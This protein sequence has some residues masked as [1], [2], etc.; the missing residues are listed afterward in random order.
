MT[1][2]MRLATFFSKVLK[3]ATLIDSCQGQRGERDAEAQ[4]APAAGLALVLLTLLGFAAT[5][6]FES[7][8]AGRREDLQTL[9]PRRIASKLA[10]GFSRLAAL[11]CGGLIA[12]EAVAR[13]LRNFRTCSNPASLPPGRAPHR[14]GLAARELREVRGGPLGIADRRGL[15]G[16]GTVSCAEHAAPEGD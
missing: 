1:S 6:A 5:Y 14:P 15:H 12:R 3:F 9:I 10:M 13:M 11:R 8:C 7:I 2:E 16:Q 4:C